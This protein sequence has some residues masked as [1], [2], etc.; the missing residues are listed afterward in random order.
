MAK[1]IKDEVRAEV[2]EMK[3]RGQRPPQLTAIIVGDD[4]A[5]HTYVR[6]KMIAARYTGPLCSPLHSSPFRTDEC[7]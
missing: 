6:N 5:S 7:F 3:A 4:P 1:G 2:E